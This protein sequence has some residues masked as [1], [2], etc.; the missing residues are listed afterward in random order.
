MLAGSSRW[1]SI[2][3]CSEYGFTRWLSK[4]VSEFPICASR[5]ALEPTACIK[6]DGNGLARVVNAVARLSIEP[7]YGVT[8][9]NAATDPKKVEVEE[10]S[11]PLVV[12]AAMVA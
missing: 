5:P 8:L 9:L 1:M 3:H 6:P 2:C 11:E 7:T 12:L 10:P 4:K